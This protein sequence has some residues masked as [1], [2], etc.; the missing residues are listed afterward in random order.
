M[1]SMLDMFSHV[2]INHDTSIFEL[3]L[4]CINLQFCLL[5]TSDAADE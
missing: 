5:Y 1:Q 4:F 3:S 2:S